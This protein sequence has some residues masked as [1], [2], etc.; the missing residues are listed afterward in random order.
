[1]EPTEDKKPKMM[2][3]KATHGLDD[4]TL[5]SDKTHTN[6]HTCSQVLV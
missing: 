3:Y 4:L 2:K 5:I 1:V 6:T